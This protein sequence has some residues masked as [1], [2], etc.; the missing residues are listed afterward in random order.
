M[1]KIT[2]SG[3]LCKDIFAF[4]VLL[5]RFGYDHILENKSLFVATL[6]EAGFRTTTGKEFTPQSYNIMID[7]LDASIVQEMKDEFG[8]VFIMLQANEKES[9]ANRLMNDAACGV[10]Y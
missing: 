7:R 5:T 10:N 3:E 1:S 9:V 6:N 2:K 8:D 4:G